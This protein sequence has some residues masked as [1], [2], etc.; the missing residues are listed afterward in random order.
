MKMTNVI[1]AIESPF[2]GIVSAFYFDIGEL[3]SDGA[4][5]VEVTSADEKEA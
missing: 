1:N 5:L 4:L 3:V 2:D